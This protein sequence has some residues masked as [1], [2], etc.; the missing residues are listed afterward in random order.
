MRRDE[1]EGTAL[2]ALVEGVQVDPSERV[3]TRVAA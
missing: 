1:G 3:P 2:R